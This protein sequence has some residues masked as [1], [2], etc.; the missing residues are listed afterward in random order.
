M[1][2]NRRRLLARVATMYYE[3]ELTQ[4]E[5]GRELELSRVKVYRLLK[6]ARATGVVDI[7]ISWPIERRLQLEAELKRATALQDAVILRS[8][9]AGEVANLRA[10]G[11]L[12]AQYLEQTLRDGM[13]MAICMGSATY[14]VI[15]AI[16]P[17]FRARV[18]VAQATGSVPFALHELDSAAVARQL[19]RTLGGEVLYLPSPLVADSVEAAAVLR[20]QT[21]IRRTLTIAANADVALLGIGTLDAQSARSVPAGFATSERLSELRGDGVVGEMAGQLFTEAGALHPGPYNQQIVGVGLEGLQRIPMVIA[22]AS[23]VEKAS[24]IL[25]ALRT[26]AVNVLITDDPTAREILEL[27]GG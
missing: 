1:D 20:D 24:A 23:G 9:R 4:S 6:E 19:A 11:Q 15:N 26:G 22:V 17:D 27:N 2:L 5:I 13:T 18:R 8:G 10:L 21:D 16:S 7:R 25:G 3:Q 14:E 12:G